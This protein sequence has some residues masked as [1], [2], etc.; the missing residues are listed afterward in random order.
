M[1]DGEELTEEFKTLCAEF[2]AGHERFLHYFRA[3][4]LAEARAVNGWMKQSLDRQREIH[5]D[6]QAI[7]DV[8]RIPV[9]SEP[10]PPRAAE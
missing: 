6:L 4:R 1:T 10:Q 2:D 7:I 3:G 8:Q 5:A 9:R